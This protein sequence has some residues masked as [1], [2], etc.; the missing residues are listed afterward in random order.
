MPVSPLTP[1]SLVASVNLQALREVF[2]ELERNHGFYCDDGG[3]CCGT[4]ATNDAWKSGAGKP[5]VFWHEQN[6]D[7]LHSSPDKPMSLYYGI[8][9]DGAADSEIVDVAKQIIKVIKQH[10][11]SCDWEGDVGESILVHLDKEPDLETAE[12]T[13][14]NIAYYMPDCIESEELKRFINESIGDVSEC[15]E[16]EPD[17]SFQFI[18]EM[19]N[20]ESLLDATMRLPAEIRQRITHFQRCLIMGDIGFKVEP[21]LGLDNELGHAGQG[22]SLYSLI[23]DLQSNR[24]TYFEE[25]FDNCYLDDIIAKASQYR[26]IL[27]ANVSK[28]ADLYCEGNEFLLSGNEPYWLVK[29][30]DRHNVRYSERKIRLADILA[31]QLRDCMLSIQVPISINGYD[32]GSNED[33]QSIRLSMPFNGVYLTVCPALKSVRFAARLYSRQQ[34]GLVQRFCNDT[35]S[36]DYII[37]AFCDEGGGKS[38]ANCVHFAYDYLVLDPAGVGMH[39]LAKATL[40]FVLSVATLAD[41]CDYLSLVTE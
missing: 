26:E 8:A 12:S 5:F 25:A 17:G 18:H 22:D 10:G 28:L 15:N 39:T 30:F 14:L 2:E 16:C 33:T 40:E 27:E 32:V 23:N 34:P 7:S 6:E 38:G 29:L 37:K 9:K 1:L 3:W 4:C 31:S 35:N 19:Q 11:F 24:E 21:V 13:H 36:S 41:S 20:G